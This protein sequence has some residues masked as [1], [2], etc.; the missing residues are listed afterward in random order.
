MN[1]LAC[2]TSFM[3]LTAVFVKQDE[4]KMKAGA[5]KT[6]PVL[7]AAAGLDYGYKIW[8]LFDFALH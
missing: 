1:V 7:K 2:G 8:V 3:R 6:Y 5:V 4:R